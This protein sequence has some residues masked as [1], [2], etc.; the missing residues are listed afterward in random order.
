MQ[1]LLDFEQRKTADP[2][3][4]RAAMARAKVDLQ[5]RVRVLPSGSEGT[6]RQMPLRY[7]CSREVRLPGSIEHCGGLRR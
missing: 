3:T 2:A 7:A 6:P 4:G 5:S 1:F